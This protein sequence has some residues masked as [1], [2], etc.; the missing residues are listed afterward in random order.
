MRKIQKNLKKMID[1]CDDEQID[2]LVNIFIKK[3]SPENSSTGYDPYIISQ[4]GELW[5]FFD[6]V[7][8][9]VPD[10]NDQNIYISFDP[11]SGFMN[12]LIEYTNV[13]GGS[14][15]ND[16]IKGPEEFV[17]LGCSLKKWLNCPIY[18]DHGSYLMITNYCY[19]NYFVG[20]PKE[21]ILERREEKVD[22]V[23]LA[24]IIWEITRFG[25]TE[26]DRKETMS[27]VQ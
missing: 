25:Y 11:E 14:K 15:Y 27:L 23:I 21:E 2:E 4:S 5:D 12:N 13:L 20:V 8:A 18:A 19:E 22:L 6:D 10:S 24:C 26:E 9:L 7:D 16:E 17:S 3:R 1:Q